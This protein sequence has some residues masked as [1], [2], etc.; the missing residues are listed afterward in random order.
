MAKWILYIL[1]RRSAPT[2]LPEGQVF[3][4]TAR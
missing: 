1:H 4:G 3:I 2:S